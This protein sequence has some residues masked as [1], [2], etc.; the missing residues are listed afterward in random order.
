MTQADKK[1]LDFSVEGLDDTEES[2]IEGVSRAAVQA[3]LRNL[4]ENAFH[5]TPEHGDV[6]LNVHQTKEALTVTVT[7]TGPGIAPEE[8]DILRNLLENAFHYTPE[9]GDV[10]LNVHQTKEA[11][12]VTVTDTGPGIA[13]EERDRVFDPFYRVVGSGLPGTG[14]GLAIVK[15]Y[16][17]MVSATVTLDDAQPGHTPPGLKVTFYCPLGSGLPG[18]GLGLA[19]V[20]TY[21]NMVSATVTLDDAQPGHTPPGLKVTFYCPLGT[22]NPR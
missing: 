13:P 18:T 3:I 11:L 1:A 17:N 12:T 21:A 19:I 4:L 5:Y 10:C 9:H 6:C 22:K 20:K 14:L 16:A 7:D 8:R 2:A 15:T